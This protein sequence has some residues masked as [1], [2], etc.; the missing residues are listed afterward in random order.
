MKFGKLKTNFY[1]NK[2]EVLQV[3][4]YKAKCLLVS[5]YYYWS[6]ILNLLVYNI[7]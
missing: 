5:C 4:N 2:F 7:I 1:N 3:F 6:W